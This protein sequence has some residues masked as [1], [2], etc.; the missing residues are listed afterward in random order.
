M[1]KP[2]ALFLAI[3]SITATSVYAED[4]QTLPTITV[5]ADKTASSSEKTK[6]YTVKD[7]SSATKLNIPVQETPQTVNVVTR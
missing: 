5:S 1:F 2:N 3:L 4:N 7:S 6:A